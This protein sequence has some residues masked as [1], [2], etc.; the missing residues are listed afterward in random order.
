MVEMEEIEKRWNQA[1]EYMI[2]VHETGD[3]TNIDLLRFIAWFQSSM[4][5]S[6][7]RSPLDV[8]HK[9]QEL[10]GF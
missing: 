9:L 1:I 3:Q 4:E 10:E 6:N 2:K 5:L 8:S 7:L